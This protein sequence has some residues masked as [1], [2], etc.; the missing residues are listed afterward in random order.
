MGM[1]KGDGQLSGLVGDHQN[2][3]EEREG[4][5][6]EEEG[7]GEEGGRRRRK[8]RTYKSSVTSTFLTP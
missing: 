8:E 6:R 5:R 2:A 1:R 7:E 4:R 3:E